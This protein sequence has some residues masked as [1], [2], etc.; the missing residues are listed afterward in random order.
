MDCNLDDGC[1]ILILSFVVCFLCEREFQIVKICAH[2]L[3]F[4]NGACQ[5]VVTI[6]YPTHKR[7]LLN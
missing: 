6:V 3:T 1:D 2:T 4:G 7:F 5:Y